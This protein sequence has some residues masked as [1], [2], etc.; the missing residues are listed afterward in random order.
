[1]TTFADLEKIAL[2][3]ARPDSVQ[4]LVQRY[5]QLAS[6]ECLND[7][8][9]AETFLDDL[10]SYSWAELTNGQGAFRVTYEN[11]RVEIFLGVDSFADNFFSFSFWNIGKSKK[12]TLNLKTNAYEV[13][14][15][16]EKGV[17]LSVRLEETALKLAPVLALAQCLKTASNQFDK[18][19]ERVVTLMGKIADAIKEYLVEIVQGTNSISAD[20]FESASVFELSRWDFIS[21][22]PSFLG[23]S[24]NYKYAAVSQANP[25]QTIFVTYKLVIC[26]Q[27]FILTATEFPDV[28]GW[29]RR[30]TFTSSG[31]VLNEAT[32][33]SCLKNIQADGYSLLKSHLADYLNP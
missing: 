8:F 18:T 10:L 28:V 2:N 23:N 7:L 12:P 17:H 25:F 11:S 4:K 20:F 29:G 27:S 16:H 24:D 33:A 31:G 15:Y 30:Y 14:G 13:A 1:M 32:R 3:L 22:D 6:A 21:E 26:G 19:F 9:L 5:N